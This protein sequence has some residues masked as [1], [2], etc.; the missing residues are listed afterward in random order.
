MH[1]KDAPAVSKEKQRKLLSWLESLRI[2]LKKLNLRL[3]SKV[4]NSTQMHQFSASATVTKK[5]D[6]SGLLR[7]IID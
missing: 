5:E 1:V 2:L 4:Q 7:G 3:R 6:T